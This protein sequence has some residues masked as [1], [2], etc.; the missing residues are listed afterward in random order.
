MGGGTNWQRALILVVVLCVLLA[1]CGS[2]DGGPGSD[3][4]DTADFEETADDSEV[5]DTADGTDEDGDADDETA[6]SDDSVEIIPVEESDDES[7]ESD[8]DDADSD[9]TDSGTDD[10]ATTEGDDTSDDDAGDTDDGADAD[11]TDDGAATD[12][13]DGATDADDE[14]GTTDDGAGD[15]GTDADDGEADDSTDD[16]ADEDEPREPGQSLLTI[17]VVD[18]AG[19]P[20][21]GVEIFGQGDEHEADIPLE[22]SGE[23]D[24]DG[25]Y[26]DV[27]YENE[28][29]IDLDHDEYEGM[30]VE[31]VHDGEYEITVT[32]EPSEPE[33]SLLTL[34]V[35]DSAG[36]SVEGVEVFG[37]GDEHEADIPLE[38]SGE[39][40]EDGLYTD[41][42]YENEYVI[43]LYHEEYETKTL[44]HTHDG[45]REVTAELE[46]TSDEGGSENAR[47]GLLP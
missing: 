1:G 31:H 32:L 30:S 43:D 9:E 11:G 33:Q 25:Q 38:F 40:D 5:D 14:D 6:E 16:A 37:Q 28:Y 10:S 23:T 19:E 4:D 29:V 3:A 42:I 21:E 36:E 24:A 39:T 22:F 34:E 26:T 35:V 8:A 15:D 2:L 44:E 20:V 46:P 13:G 12:D 17:T 45:E 27:I 18:S 41:V 47:L 7:D